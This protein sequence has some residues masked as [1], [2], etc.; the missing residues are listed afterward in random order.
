MLC[1][2][3]VRLAGSYEALDAGNTADAFVDF[4]GG[5]SEFIN[6]ETGGYADDEEQRNLLFTVNGYMTMVLY[7]M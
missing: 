3:C 1:I 7:M 4:S 2:F 6:L 5:V